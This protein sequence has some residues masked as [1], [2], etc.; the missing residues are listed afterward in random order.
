MWLL[1]LNFHV[2]RM[3]VTKAAIK[4]RRHF[5]DVPICLARPLQ[6]CRAVSESEDGCMSVFTCCTVYYSLRP[7][8]SLLLQV[9]LGFSKTRLWDFLEIC[10]AGFVTSRVPCLPNR[11]RQ[12]SE[13]FLCTVDV[14]FVEINASR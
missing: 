12:S 1:Y 13:R 8:F 2:F 14:P 11:Q 10:A 9:R 4:Q 7:S 3:V 6:I 5:L